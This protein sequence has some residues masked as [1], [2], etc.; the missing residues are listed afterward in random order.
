M[1]HDDEKQQGAGRTMFMFC[2][3]YLGI[4]IGALVF[5]LFILLN[6]YAFSDQSLSNDLANKYT[7][8][9]EYLRQEQEALDQQKQSL[10]EEVVNS[11]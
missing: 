4:F 8:I 3:S 1:Y 6:T 10:L 11:T 5:M 2:R 9:A 7:Q